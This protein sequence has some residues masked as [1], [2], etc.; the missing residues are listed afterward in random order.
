MSENGEPPGETWE[1]IRPA[2]R[3]VRPARS[4]DEAYL[5]PSPPPPPPPPP[6]PPEAQAGVPLPVV[7][8]PDRSG[9]DPLLLDRKAARQ[10]MRGT[11]RARRNQRRSKREKVFDRLLR[12]ALLITASAAVAGALYWTLKIRENRLAAKRLAALTP[13]VSTPGA[14][15]GPRVEAMMKAFLEAPDAAAKSA[16]VL[17]SVRV[18]PLMKAAYA[19]GALQESGITFGVP[20]PI[21]TG[22]LAVPV[23]APGPPEILLHVLVR[24]L[25]DGPRL[26]W[27]TYEQEL[28]QRF[29]RFVEKPAS[30]GGEYRVILERS[31]PFEGARSGVE[32]VKLA[33]PGGTLY[34]RPVVLAPEAVTAVTNGLPWNKRRRALVRL[35]WVAE[36]GSAPAVTVRELVRWDFLP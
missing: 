20:Q 23:Q 29:L 9:M 22:V 4:A 31:H 34:N 27:E 8:K 28:N 5:P 6:M 21:G 32:A 30:E 18:L 13:A 36:D 17:D 35:E 7:E 24:D 33:T 19:A 11:T 10:S 25:P 2:P 26:D 3:P 14:T 16:F 15:A 1:R 12:T